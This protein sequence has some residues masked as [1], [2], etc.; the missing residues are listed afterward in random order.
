[1]ANFPM[2][3]RRWPVFSRI[4]EHDKT[5]EAFFKNPQGILPIIVRVIRSFSGDL[6][7]R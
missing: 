7:G 4:I 3:K 1:M 6:R 2:K 5:F